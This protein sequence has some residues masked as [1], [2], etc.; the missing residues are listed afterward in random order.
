MGTKNGLGNITVIK[1]KG[2]GIALKG[3]NPLF[4]EAKKKNL[5]GDDLVNFLIKGLKILNALSKRDEESLKEILPIKYSKFLKGEPD[6]NGEDD[7]NKIDIKILGGC[8]KNSF[9]LEKQA[10]DAVIELEVE[11]PFIHIRDQAKIREFGMIPTPALVINGRI[12]SSGR[13]V[14]KDEIKKM[15]LEA[16]QKDKKRTELS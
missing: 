8:C 5:E 11:G 3:V 10:M 9:E 7:K 4:L 2:V 6:K 12:V 15:I 14:M 1:I 16:M 13:V